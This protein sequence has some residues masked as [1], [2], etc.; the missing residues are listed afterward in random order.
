[1]KDEKKMFQLAHTILTDKRND[2][3]YGMSFGIYTEAT[4]EHYSYWD[5]LN[6]LEEAFQR[7][8]KRKRE[9]GAENV[10]IQD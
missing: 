5:M 1:M 6:D 2:K 4:N 7:F 10:Q 8:M 3:R 9:E